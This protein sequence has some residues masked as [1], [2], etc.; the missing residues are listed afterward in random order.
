LEEIEFDSGDFSFSGE[1]VVITQEEL[2][3]DDDEFPNT[4]TSLPDGI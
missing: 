1:G 4:G 2:D 3:V